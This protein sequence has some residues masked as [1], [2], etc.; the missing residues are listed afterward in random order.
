MGTRLA[1]DNRQMRAL[2]LIQGENGPPMTT[3]GAS[4]ADRLD[5][6]KAIAEYLGRD[7][8]TVRRWERTLGLPVRRVAGHRGSSVFAFKSEIDLWLQREAASTTT[9]ED[10]APAARAVPAV[11]WGG[12]AFLVVAL[13]GWWWVQRPQIDVRRLQVEVVADGVLAKG[14]NGQEVWR[15][16]LPAGETAA[17]SPVGRSVQ[18]VAGADPAVF[19]AHSYRV[20]AGD[21]AESG[22]LMSFTPDGRRRWSFTFDDVLR[23]GGKQF[24]APWVITDFTVDESHLPRRTAVAAHHYLWGASMVAILD[25]TGRRLSTFAHSGWVEN[26]HWLGDRLVVGGFSEARDGGMVALLDPA[27]A[28]GQGAED[29]ASGHHCENC[30]ADRALR[31]VV[32]PRTE[33]N[34]LTH[35]RFNRAVVQITPDHI[36][37]RTIEV[38]S[39]GQEAVDAIY[40]FTPDLTLV[41]ASF[42]ARYWEIHDAMQ[43]QG[44]LDHDR[45]RCPDR[46]G[47]RELREWT[48]AAG[49]TAIEIGQ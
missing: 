9:V 2:V 32:M 33:V 39:M 24:G 47:P 14:P 8:G 18:L 23:F 5:S 13:A 25:D 29:P 19:A 15:D 22:S 49:W 20:R 6:W 35:S 17:V 28:N 44:R 45:S 36:I 31:M 4:P 3:T 1:I 21:Q 48:L 27:R 10:P 38:P 41:R 26:V 11:V 40:E 12:I 16:R 46:E 34:R 30:G 42:S 7:V 37:A 43:G